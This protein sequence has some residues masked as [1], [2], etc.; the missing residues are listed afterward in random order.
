MSRERNHF[1]IKPTCYLVEFIPDGVEVLLDGVAA[2]GD[3]SHADLDIGVTLALDHAPHEVV[4][5][6]QV[7][8]L[9]QMDTQ[10]SL[11][12]EQG[13]GMLL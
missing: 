7:L 3:T 2:V 9:H 13:W 11:W 10:H 4:L 6:Y 12:V 5:G 8:G 1:S